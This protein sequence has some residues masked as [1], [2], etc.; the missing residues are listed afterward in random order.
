MFPGLADSQIRAW[1]GAEG[2]A[3][4]VRAYGQW[5]RDEAEKRIGHLYPKA[6]LPGGGEATVIAW[7]WARTVICPNPA[8]G[9]EMPLVRSWWLGKKEG[10]E[11]FVLPEVILDET[12]PSG[13]RV[14]FKIGHDAFNA[15]TAEN[16]GTI[17]RRG[18]ICVACQTG[19]DLKY[20][21]LE[22]KAGRIGTQLMA[23]VAE[24][25][26]RRIYCAPLHSHESAAQI[27]RPE[28]VPEGEL[29]SNPRDFKT[30]NYGMTHWADLFTNRQLM[31]LTTFSDLVAE[32]RE[33]ILRDATAG[34]MP[35]G[36]RLES[37][38]V[39]A[40]AYAD[41]VSTYLGMALS[42][43]L[44]K[45]STICSWDSSP[46]MEAVRG[47]FARQ[48]I[49]MAWDFAE[50]NPFGGSSGDYLE[51]LGWVSKALERVPALAVDSAIQA[52]AATRDYRGALVSTDPPYYD[53][54]GYSDLSDYLYV[55]L[56][57]SLR[58]IHPALF[59]TLLVPKAE[60][61]V[62]NPYRQDGKEGAKSFF[63]EGFRSVF[64]RARESASLDFPITVYYAFKQ[65]DTDGD[66]E[67]SSGWE[68][69]L[70]GMVSNSWTVTATWP[71][72]SEMV[73]RPIAGGTNALASSIVLALRPRPDDASTTDRRGFIAALQAELP[74]ALRELQ[75]GAIAPV[76]L[77]QAAIGP[78]M[79]VFSRYASVIEADGSN[80]K[81][82]SALARINEVLDQVLSEQEG[83][84]DST[85][86]F[87]IAWYRQHGYGVGTF[88][89]ADNLAR[90]RNTSVSSLDRDEVLTSRAGKVQLLKP[91]GLSSDYDVIA[92]EHT[93]AWE[94]SHHLMRVLDSD[95]LIAAGQFLAQAESRP[96]GAVDSALVKELSFLLFSIAEKNGWT[97][98]A[99]SFNALATSWSDIVAESRQVPRVQTQ[100]AF[101]FDED[102]E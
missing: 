23:I 26:R 13:K 91:A 7:I 55:W 19:V 66:G 95:G 80:M 10:K 14:E 73:N 82:R 99:L 79:G 33:L 64:A 62:A 94:A 8:C 98:D 50:A 53:N 76:D 72:R 42:R 85:S 15:P 57:R 45:S 6:E 65:S 90:A 58:G 102:D 16:D 100:D 70:D 22:G 11:A 17:G 18:G 93:S 69:L 81:V 86:R 2:L 30:P 63:E 25:S 36:E 37:G 78:G 74:K 61:L 101:E 40:A 71:I 35:K 52:D 20:V 41:A 56:R 75:Q 87:A 96:D 31:S 24:G 59:D 92:D 12:H 97:K 3:A 83:D 89:D 27:D 34:A 43:T 1:N 44:N 54:I 68:T 88:G 51:D 5:M 84:F 21:R 32:T 9:I 46:K 38:G 60:E 4:D 67:S 39:E 29:P 48:A 77:P 47:L 49:P 28:D